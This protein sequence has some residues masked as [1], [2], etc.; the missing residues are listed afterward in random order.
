MSTLD[1]LFT[2]IVFDS[3]SRFST[4]WNHLYVMVCFV[5]T[6]FYIFAIVFG[7]QRNIVDQ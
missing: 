2:V 3:E 7:I 1:L 4:I 5:S 6:Y